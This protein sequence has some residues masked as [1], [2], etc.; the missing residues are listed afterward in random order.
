M[1]TQKKLGRTANNLNNL[2]TRKYVIAAKLCPLFQGNW[3]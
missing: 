2:F 1:D 3:Q